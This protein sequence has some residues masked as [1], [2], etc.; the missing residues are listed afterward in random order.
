MQLQNKIIYYNKY[1]Y[2]VVNFDDKHYY[3]NKLIVDNTLNIEYDFND[4]INFQNIQLLHFENK[5]N[6]KDEIKVKKTKIKSKKIKIIDDINNYYL[7][8]GELKDNYINIWS[9]VVNAWNF[10]AEMTV[11][12]KISLL[13]NGKFKK[14]FKNDRDNELYVFCLLICNDTIKLKSGLSYLDIIKKL[15][16]D[17]IFDNLKKEAIRNELRKFIK[18]KNACCPVCLSSD[19]DNFKGLYKCSHHI[20]YDCYD[21]WKIKTCP[22]CRAND[23]YINDDD[24]ESQN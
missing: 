5:V 19:V 24:D 16:Y 6:E 8:N 22:I 7:S 12:Y 15:G 14:N 9:N 2:R 3:I 10:E 1:L 11:K 18:I 17:K 13:T 4:I 21:K 20:C 23:N